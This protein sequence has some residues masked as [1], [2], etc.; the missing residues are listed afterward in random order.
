[1][2]LHYPRGDCFSQ[3]LNQRKFLQKLIKCII[4]YCYFRKRASSF[5]TCPGFT[6]DRVNFFSVAGT[7]LC[8]GFRMRIMLITLMLILVFLSCIYDK[9]RAS[10]WLCSCTASDKV[11]LRKAG[12]SI[13]GMGDLNLQK[14][15]C[16]V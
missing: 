2:D 15:Y 6:W 4:T 14:G 13:A 16:R 3:G 1:M 9:L 10:F 8:F 12:E 7:V 11:H 5:A